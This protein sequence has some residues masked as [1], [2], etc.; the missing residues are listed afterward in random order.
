[1]VDSAEPGMDRINTE[2][3]VSF[4]VRDDS[5]EFRGRGQ[6]AD[7]DL[8]PRMDVLV[9]EVRIIRDLIEERL[10]RDDGH[11]AMV[12]SL[13]KE[14]DESRRSQSGE[15]LRSV[16][17]DVILVL[18]RVTRAMAHAS[19]ALMMQS[20]AEELLEV[21]EKQGVERVVITDRATLDPQVQQVVGVDP[22]VAAPMFRYKKVRDGYRYRNRVLRSEQVVSSEPVASP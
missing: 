17:L 13:Y 11:Q 7:C 14:L 22:T 15:G 18:D 5:R 19:D 8:A 16:L 4:D 21:L 20:V 2:S 3:V 12:T 1:M 6:I 10:E 9:G